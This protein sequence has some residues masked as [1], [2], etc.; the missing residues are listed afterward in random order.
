[1]KNLI[2]FIS[3]HVTHHPVSMF[4][5]DIQTNAAKLTEEILS[6]SVCVIGGAG[7]IGSS[8]IKAGIQ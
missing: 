1:M 8:I 2:L 4:E 3:D 6:K 7:S 5:A